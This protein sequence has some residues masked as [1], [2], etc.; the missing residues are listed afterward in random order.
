[1]RAQV[2]I[3]GLVQMVGFRA[4][5]R[6]QARRLGVNGWVRNRQDGNVELLMEGERQAVEK[7]IVWCGQGPP[8]A[9]V[10]GVEVT[11]EE[12]HGEVEGFTIRY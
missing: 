7:L 5:A 2:T 6:Q 11:W 10:K 12:Y 8:G 9:V 4:S 1:M 3:T